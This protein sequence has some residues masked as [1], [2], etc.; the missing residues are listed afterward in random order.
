V[1]EKRQRGTKYEFATRI[2]ARAERMVNGILLN[3]GISLPVAEPYPRAFHAAWNLGQE[4]ILLRLLECNWSLEDSWLRR[5]IDQNDLAGLFQALEEIN[6]LAGLKLFSPESTS[7]LE[8]KTEELAGFVQELYQPAFFPKQPLPELLGG[9]IEKMPDSHPGQ[10]AFFTPPRLAQMMADESFT[11]LGL[12]QCQLDARDFT[13][14]DPSFGSGNF[15][16]ALLRRIMKVEVDFYTRRPL[17]YPLTRLNDLSPSIEFELKVE[18]CREHLFGLELNEKNRD[19]ALRA[20]AVLLLQGQKLFEIK[21]GAIAFLNQNLALGD[22]LVD[23]PLREQIDL[24]NQDRSERL[25]PFSFSDPNVPHHRA[26]AAGGFDLVIGNPPWLSLKGKRGA[27]PYSRDVVN[28]LIENYQA[29]SYRPNL[30]EMFMRKAVV[31]L[32]ENGVNC[33]IVPDRMA[34]NL[35]FQSLRRFLVEQGEILR[36]HFREPFPGVV[37]DTL[38][39][40]FQKKK[41]AAKKIKLSDSNGKQGEVSVRKFIGQ[42][43]SIEKEFSEEFASLLAKIRQQAKSRMDNFFLC[44][45]GL[46]G[47]PGSIHPEK[48]AASDQPIIK[49]EN[50]QRWKISGNYFFDFHKRN[51]LGGTTRY[52]KLTARERILVRKTGLKLIAAID[53][54]GR[55]VEQSAYYLIP[56]PGKKNKLA[57]EYFLGLLNS[58]LLNFYYRNFLITNPQSTPQLKKFHL[59]ELPVKKINLH[60]QAEKKLYDKITALAGEL[61]GAKD[62]EEQKKLERELNQAVFKLHQLTPEEIKLLADY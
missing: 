37:S 11:Y 43:G 53:N 28:W 2:L 51:F 16:L 18:L 55:L 30:F 6:Q 13:I 19:S 3:R 7:E 42:G 10:A 49:G 57:L 46:I 56:K 4:L 31:L 23:A 50:I 24:F 33:F 40:W 27:S 62:P 47:R 9:L 1:A 29:N 22:F 20:L 12:D 45:V 14:L 39:Y 61:G 34:E 44:G 15:L 26:I 8:L 32:R 48:Q 52:P 60:D 25:K 36:L 58:Q 17:L 59:L 41:P 5:F 38:I 35:Q 54:S 21:P